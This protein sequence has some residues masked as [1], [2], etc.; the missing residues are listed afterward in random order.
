[1]TPHVAIT[2]KQ[3]PTSQALLRDRLAQLEA[4]LLE[5]RGRVMFS[6]DRELASLRGWMDSLE[7]FDPAVGL[8]ALDEPAI[9]PIGESLEALIAQAPHPAASNILPFSTFGFADAASSIL[10]EQPLDPTLA[11]ATLDELNAALTA[12]FQHMEHKCPPPEPRSA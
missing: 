4:T 12:A 2:P 9:A 8:Q 3:P 5:A 7:H 6:F 11:S 10:E 1:M